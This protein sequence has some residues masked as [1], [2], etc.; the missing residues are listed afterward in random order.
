MPDVCSAHLYNVTGYER[1]LVTLESSLKIPSSGIL[2]G[3]LGRLRLPN[4][5]T[6]TNHQTQT[7]APAD[8]P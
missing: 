2:P 4:A 7:R 1:F 3:F 5:K 6:S 8:E